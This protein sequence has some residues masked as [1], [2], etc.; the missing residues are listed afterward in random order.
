MFVFVSMSAYT[1]IVELLKSNSPQFESRKEFMIK[2]DGLR[3]EAG[4]VPT[5]EL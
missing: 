5:E 1:V 2:L 3:V 4:S